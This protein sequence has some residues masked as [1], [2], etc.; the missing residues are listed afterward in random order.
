MGE[1][2]CCAQH[3]SPFFIVC[4][5]ENLYLSVVT[6]FHFSIFDV[7]RTATVNSA[8]VQV[9]KRQRDQMY[10]VLDV[11]GDYIHPYYTDD[12]YF[13]SL[14]SDLRYAKWKQSL[15]QC[16]LSPYIKKPRPLEVANFI[17]TGRL[18]Y[19]NLSLQKP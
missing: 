13:H 17:I 3:P 8:A 19:D 16:Q 12:L 6:R 14:E 5:A 9:L 15:R 10:A 18:I 2:R 11:Q 1:E 7:L 4:S